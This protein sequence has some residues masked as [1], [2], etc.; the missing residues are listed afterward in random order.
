MGRTRFESLAVLGVL[1]LSL[2]AQAEG[3]TAPAEESKSEEASADGAPEQ[4]GEVSED[5]PQTDEGAQAEEAAPPE[6]TVDPYA[7]AKERVGRAEQLFEDGNYDAALTEFQRAYD[8]MLGHPARGYVLFNIGK[9]QE[10]LYRYDAA[11][12]S[13]RSYLE[14]AQSD[15]EDRPAVEAK[16]E[17]LEGL[18]GTLRITVSADKGPAPSAYEIWV[19]GRM[20]GESV[21]HFLV[22]AGNHQIEIRAEG[23][24]PK[25][26]EVQLPARA[27]KSLSFTL[28]PLAKEYKGL[29]STYFWTSTGLAAASGVTGGAFGLVALSKRKDADAKAQEAVT[30]DEVDGIKKSALWA[31]VFFISAGVFATTS[32][33][34]A[35]MTDWSEAETESPVKVKEVGFFPINDGGVVSIGGSF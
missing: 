11:I 18:L 15:A 5:D 9:C 28:L 19:D 14:I 26:Q 4:Q 29:S 3:T 24:E 7:E 21:N 23:F 25:S 20:V 22:P 32:V 33:I 31:D 2:N 35:F 30:Q 1:L 16:I 13:Y 17:L 12:Q 10:K 8:T 34:L 6:E 27:E